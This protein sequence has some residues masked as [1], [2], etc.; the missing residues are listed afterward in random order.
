MAE[1]IDYSGSPSHGPIEPLRWIGAYKLLKAALAVIGGL[2]VLRLRHSN[3]VDATFR[4]LERLRIDAD[5]RAGIFLI[6][7]ITAIRPTDFERIAIALFVYTPLGIAE[8]L[9]LI[10]KKTWAE[11]LTVITTSA[12]VPVEI[13]ESVRRPTWVRITILVLNV[14]V[15]VYLVQRIRRDHLRRN[16]LRSS[17]PTDQQNCSRPD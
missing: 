13:I 17:T 4:L 10:Y 8:G 3:S 7:R 1:V 9:G 5:S 16:R 2:I 11:W 14:A 15:L 6:R 12:L